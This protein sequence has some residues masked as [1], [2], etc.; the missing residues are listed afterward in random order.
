MLAAGIA[1][2]GAA[3]EQELIGRTGKP[4]GWLTASHGEPAHEQAGCRRIQRKQSTK[5]GL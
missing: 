4:I 5:L 2:V 3:M 1:H